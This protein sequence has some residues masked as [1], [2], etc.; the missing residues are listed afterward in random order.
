MAYCPG[1]PLSL[2]SRSQVVLMTQVCLT[3]HPSSM[4]RVRTWSP[5]SGSLAQAGVGPLLPPTQCLPPSF[6]HR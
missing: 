3:L 1:S 2:V 5:H 6:P 4:L